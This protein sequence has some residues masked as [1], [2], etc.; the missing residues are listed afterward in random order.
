M[1]KYHVHCFAIVR[2][3][4]PNVTAT[5]PREAIEA[6]TKAVNWHRVLV[7]GYNLTLPSGE[8]ISDQEFAEEFSHFLVDEADDLECARSAWYSPT[9][10]PMDIWPKRT[11]PR[12]MAKR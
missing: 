12:R 10:K 11:R 6:A 4:V 1:P 9:L 5:N 8:P 3:R 2:V 7:D